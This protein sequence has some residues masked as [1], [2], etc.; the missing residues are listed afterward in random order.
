MAQRALCGEVPAHAVHADARRRGRRAE[1]YA[2]DRS[3][4]RVEREYRPGEELPQVGRSAGDVTAHE[5]RVA[6]LEGCRRRLVRRDDAIAKARREP[7]D[8]PLHGLA[9]VD[10]RS[11]RYMAVGP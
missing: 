6:A 3:P 10:G 11:I 9:H 4:M 8:L 1:V 2:V 7:F 5:I